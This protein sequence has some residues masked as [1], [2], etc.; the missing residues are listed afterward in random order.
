MRRKEFEHLARRYQ[1]DIFSAA[2]R[3]TGNYSDA[4]DLAQ[5]AFLKAYMAFDQFQ[6]GTN[7]RAWLLRILTNTHINRYRRGKRTPD[8]IAWEDFTLQGERQDQVESPAP[9]RPEQEVLSTVPDEV[10]GPALHQLPEEFREA[11]I[12]SDIHELSYKEIAATLDIPL[13]TVRSRI[14]RG[15]KLLRETLADYARARR[16]V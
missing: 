10:V 8:T 12:L 2:L 1:R 7:F 3:L 15:R 11:V 16:M 14:F 5:E 4:E 6:L 9:Q 13:G